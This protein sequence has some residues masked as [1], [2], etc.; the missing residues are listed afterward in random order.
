MPGTDPGATSDDPTRAASSRRTFLTKAAL[1]AGAA[2]AAPTVLSSQ[3][4]AGPGTAPSPFF[5]AA[6]N[7]GTANCLLFCGTRTVSTARPGGVTT[8]DVLVAIVGAD[9]ADTISSF[10]GWTLRSGPNS[11][12][13]TDS[14]RSWLYTRT[15]VAAEPAT[16]TVTFSSGSGRGPLRVAVAAFRASAPFTASYDTSTSTVTSVATS[17]P[18]WPLVTPSSTAGIVVRLGVTGRWESLFEDLLWTTP[19]PG[20]DV[21]IQTTENDFTTDIGSRAAHI[22]YG[23]TGGAAN[24]TVVRQNFITCARPTLQ[25]RQAGTNAD[26]LISSGPDRVDPR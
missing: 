10:P 16:Y 2:W 17:S 15:V 9:T 23:A 19:N 5:V 20:A 4:A 11:T 7:G 26:A 25:T 21:A 22:S 13:A 18:P 6:S 24:G 12:T 8:G 3:A 1:G 14:V